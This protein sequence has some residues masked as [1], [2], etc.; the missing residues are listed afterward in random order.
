MAIPLFDSISIMCRRINQGRS[1]FSPD[2]EHLHHLLSRS[3]F[4]VNQKLIIIGSYSVLL[5]ISGFASSFFLGIPE[6][7]L[8]FIYLSIFATFYWRINQAWKAIEI[9]YPLGSHQEIDERRTEERRKAKKQ[10]ESDK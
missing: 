8:F 5:S 10:Q 2:R 3:G 6:Q 1:P 7:V 9:T 4:S